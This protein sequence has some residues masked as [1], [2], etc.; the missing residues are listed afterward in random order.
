MI[1]LTEIYKSDTFSQAKTCLNGNVFF[2]FK[3]VMKRLMITCVMLMMVGTVKGQFA[4]VNTDGSTLNPIISGVGSLGTP[5]YVAS[6]SVISF[7]VPTAANAGVGFYEW[8]VLGGKITGG[9]NESS[10]THVASYIKKSNSLAD[11]NS[12]IQITWENKGFSGA[13]IAVKQTSEYGCTDGAW[14]I[15]YISIINLESASVQLKTTGDVCKG[16]YM[17]MVFELTGVDT[18]YINSWSVD[19]EDQLSNNFNVDFSVFTT[20]PSYTYKLNTGTLPANTY[21]Y[22]LS[23]FKLILKQGN[24]EVVKTATVDDNTGTVFPLPSTRAI[25]HN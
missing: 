2:V 25:E 21:T 5:E 17:D 8:H 4:N 6:S 20:H 16:G 14:S 15:Y 23:N 13:W 11:L 3:G 18:Q 22:S 7:T 19:V 10:G 1:R 12:T 24:C 9:S